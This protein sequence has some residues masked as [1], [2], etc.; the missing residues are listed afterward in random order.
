M[1]A[2]SH[3]AHRDSES[4]RQQVRVIRWVADRYRRRADSARLAGEL[5]T[6]RGDRFPLWVSEEDLGTRRWDVA[7]E[8]LRDGQ[9]FIFEGVGLHFEKPDLLVVTVES[10]DAD[11]TLALADAKFER[12]LSC[13]EMLSRQDDRFRALVKQRRVKFELIYDYGMGAVLVAVRDGE[14]TRLT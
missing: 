14:G 7:L 3:V 8:L 12:A 10:P 9:T 6:L 2:S 11:T 5:S 4:P 1:P 13:F